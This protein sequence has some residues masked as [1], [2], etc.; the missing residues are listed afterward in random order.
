MGSYSYFHLLMI[1]FIFLM[2]L[3]PILL[4]A[5][6]TRRA[7]R[8]KNVTGQNLYPCPDCGRMVSRSAP[9]CPQCGR[10]QQE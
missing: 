4:V 10:P 5:F 8:S 3:W 9:T 6:L 1:V 2:A 7:A